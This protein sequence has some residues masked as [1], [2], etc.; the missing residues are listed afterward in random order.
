MADSPTSTAERLLPS[1]HRPRA[2]HQALVPG[3]R[4]AVHAGLDR[5][6]LKRIPAAA[7]EAGGLDLL[8]LTPA[9]LRLRCGGHGDSGGSNPDSA[10]AAAQ[11]QQRDDHKR[12]ACHGAPCGA[13]RPAFR[14]TP[15]A[16]AAVWSPSPTK[17]NARRAHGGPI[18]RALRLVALL[19]LVA[20]LVGLWTQNVV[21][22]R[23]LDALRPTWVDTYQPVP[24]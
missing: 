10:A 3:V 15:G 12:T 8:A 7:G 24:A 17:A 21:L 16:A 20:A 13:A 18:R 2:A 14:L 6:A 1:S 5:G 9:G 22:R 19:W 23:D 11:G 4:A